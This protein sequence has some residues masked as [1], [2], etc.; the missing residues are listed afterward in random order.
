MTVANL[1]DGL[2]LIDAG[3]WVFGGTD[4]NEERAATINGIMRMHAC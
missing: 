4:S 3:I 1:T 2:G